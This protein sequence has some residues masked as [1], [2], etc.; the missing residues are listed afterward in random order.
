MLQRHCDGVNDTPAGGPLMRW[1]GKAA[2][3]TVGLA[4]LGPL[5]GL[6]GT[7]LG[8]QFDRG[9]A[10]EL[11]RPRAR[12]SAYPF[13]ETLLESTFS[14]MGYIAALDGNVS[15]AEKKTVTRIVSA[16]QL[17][18]VRARSAWRAFELGTA[19]NFHPERQLKRLAEVSRGR[20][21]LLN[22]FVDMQL[23]VALADG[24]LSGNTRVELKRICRGLGIGAVELA[25]AEALAR[26]RSGAAQAA[27]A[28]ERDDPV[29]RA[30][31]VLGVAHDADEAT[32]KR[33]YRRLMNRHHPDKLVGQNLDE[34]ALLLARE[35]THQVRVAYETVMAA[36]PKPG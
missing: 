1:W 11:D 28:L 22:A 34:S 30:R 29:A 9:L 2:G 27:A 19:A 35:R 15:A 4:F 32:I 5:G 17:D 24:G 20:R 8:H 23:R 13:R 25:Q 18:K 26:V 3:G 10:E 33:A 12:T 7:V 16:L 31:D 36:R 6:I 14:I 21:D